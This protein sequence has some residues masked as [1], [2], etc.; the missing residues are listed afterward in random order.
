MND[1]D[2]Y[3]QTFTGKRFHF[4]HPTPDE[5]CLEDVAH[6]LAMTC[7]YGGAVKYFYSVAQHSVLVSRASG[8]DPRAR[9]VGLLHDAA[10]AYLH[11]L[12]PALKVL[13][14]GYGI[15]TIKADN[16]IR[17]AFGVPYEWVHKHGDAVK[18]A[19]LRALACEASQL[20]MPRDGW[21]GWKSLQGIEPLAVRLDDPGMCWSPT[22]GA[23]FFMAEY[24]KLRAL[25]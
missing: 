1:V 13:V 14:T 20:M 3:R 25:I 11:D 19:D 10:E 17:D 24:Q 5:V 16:A 2:H 7:R 8:T 4:L 21:A 18:H 23:G 9:L 15:L 12:H 6:H 22:D